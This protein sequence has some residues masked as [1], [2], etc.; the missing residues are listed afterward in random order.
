[1]HSTIGK[2]SFALS[3][4]LAS[5]LFG[6]VPGESELR[7][8]AKLVQTAPG[9]T[10]VG[11]RGA[12]V[13]FAR[14]NDENPGQNSAPSWAADLFDPQREG[15]ISHFYDEMS[16][17]RLR[18]RG[19]VASR[20]YA[21]LGNT[22]DYL[23][24][25]ADE[26][27]DYARFSREILEQADGDIDFA[28]FD[29]DGV[30]GVPNSGDDDGL[31]DGVFIVVSSAPRN[32]LIG[33][34]TGIADLG[35]MPY[36]TNDRGFDGRPIEIR[37]GS[38]QQGRSFAETSG[39]IC[40]E[41]AHLI[42]DLPDLY[43]IN[44]I[45]SGSDDPSEDSA[46]IGNWGLMAWGAL[47]W[48]GD[49]GP[50][51]FSA[52]SRMRLGWA[53]LQTPVQLEQ[54]LRIEPVGTSGKVYQVP[55]PNGEFF[56]L[57][58]RTRTGSFYDRN[59]PAEG[60]LVWHVGGAKQ[61]GQI[62]L[63]CAD[64]RFID[65]GFPL[66][67]QPESVAGGD[68]LDFWSRD[69]VFN[70]TFAGNLGDETDPFDGVQFREF[71]PESNPAALSSDLQWDARIENIRRDNEQMVADITISPVV[72]VSQ[73]QVLDGNRDGILVAGE[74]ADLE[75]D[76][77]TPGNSGAL[78]TVISG[79]D[80][81]VE[82]IRAEAIYQIDPISQ[83]DRQGPTRYRLAGE[84]NQL[85]LRENFAGNSE[86][87]VRVDVQEQFGDGWV[88]LWSEEVELQAVAARQE[89]AA[90]A[91]I[92]SMGNG[93]GQVQAGEIFHL[94]LLL[95]LVVPEVLQALDFRLRSLDAR[96]E[97]LGGG[98]LSFRRPNRYD[99][100]SAVGPEFLAGAQIATG[101]TLDFE[102]EVDSGFAL[103]R[104]TLQVQV[105][106][107]VDRTPPR[108]LGV[109]ARSREDGLAVWLPGELVLDGGG[110]GAARVRVFT[111]EG[112]TG[113]V[114]E[115]TLLDVDGEFAGLW[116]DAWPGT[117]YLLQT[118]VVDA[119]GNE[120]RSP[121][122]RVAIPVAEESRAD[123]L[124]VG[125]IDE[126]LGAVAISSDSRWLAVA[127]G[128]EV[129][130]YEGEDLVL[131]R[132]FSAD[133][134]RALAFDADGDLLAVGGRDGS[135]RVWSM[136]DGG[137]RAFFAAHA[138]PVAALAFSQL[139]ELASVGGDGRLLI[140]D[141]LAGGQAEELTLPGGVALQA[142]AFSNNGR[143]LAVATA[144]AEV[145]LWTGRQRVESVLLGHEGL[146]E[147]ISFSADGD[148]L[149]SGGRDGQV[150]VWNLERGGRGR[151]LGDGGAWVQSVVFSADGKW[152][153]AGGWDGRIRVWDR[154]GFQLERSL[155][156]GSGV[157][158]LG[159]GDGGEGARLLVGTWE[160]ALLLRLDDGDEM[161][162]Q[163]P[164]P[165][166]FPAYP[167]PFNSAVRIPYRLVV[168]SSVMLRVYDILGQEVRRV[169]LGSQ[170]A[171]Y[172][173]GPGRAVVWDGRDQQGRRV[174][175]GFY[176]YEVQAGSR[177]A[178]RKIA[179]VQ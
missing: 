143:H 109:K 131:Q 75:F 78:R 76:L 173:Y 34:A 11:S 39:T 133:Y 148:W 110:I 140:W 33:A 176:I 100:R 154:V 151:T 45:R 160:G 112:G 95:D 38:I 123:Q 83:L 68:N 130:V 24:A 3:L 57:E 15:S 125:R 128:S 27:G 115:I 97:R 70:E 2:R 42:S 144:N 121:L 55:M 127:D 116:P 103:W 50:V 135:L 58:Y 90:V 177:K 51:S 85:S 32:F 155:D 124:A 118:V 66:G 6:A 20:R 149:A 44:F 104:D 159:F 126:R 171:G 82:L 93:D 106:P 163:A 150:W 22:R 35:P 29:N 71:T 46:G 175:S 178:R 89:V 65:A 43:D 169:D 164:A 145:I 96:V 64:G 7:C 111:A 26:V 25:S 79:P 167:N 120:G 23:A 10:S 8:A 174:G 168:D 13:I 101:S 12:V 31:V 157:E 92:D 61:R 74:T 141:L 86:A 132:T 161:A 113:P 152:L 4:V 146:V 117:E 136:A 81:L 138:G 28:R 158:G 36:R 63:E 84:A 17:G 139:G 60:L 30:D 105:A 80:S 172:Y 119:A 114:A 153:A 108:V 91:I 19:E 53:T 18:L 107:G 14:F 56:L 40:H 16:F 47:G 9:A 165:V 37:A 67:N 142:V 170:A 98:Q 99:Q 54:E 41:Y 72:R 122:Q 21:S 134:A 73:V 147:S 62:D 162:G 94:E 179:L 88:L 137:E 102:L 166:L 52:W 59:I 77:L 129:R 48:H 49:D 87:S 1:M 69:A 5:S 156:A